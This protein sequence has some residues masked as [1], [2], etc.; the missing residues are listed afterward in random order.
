MYLDLIENLGIFAIIISASAWVIRKY[1][2]L[3]FS[4]DLEKFKSNLEKESIE[5][6]IRYEKLHSERAEVIKEVYKKIVKTYKSFH[7]LMNPIQL[8]GELKEEEK[9][10]LA[11]EEVNKLIDYYEE[12][13]I[14]FEENIAIAIDKLLNEFRKSWHQFGYSRILRDDRA[15]DVDE[16]NK[17]WEQISK[18][19]PEIKVMIEKEFR[20]IIGV[21]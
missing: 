13:R 21:E 11:V 1:A 9:S 18:E 12:N 8:A 7:S 2:E 16:W 3:I 5:F 10:K 4:R 14:F 15:P 6:K 17:A 20:K 19:I